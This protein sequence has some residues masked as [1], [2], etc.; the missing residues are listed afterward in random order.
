MDKEINSAATKNNVIAD[1]YNQGF[2]VRPNGGVRVCLEG[3]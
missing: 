1:S 2:A 3:K